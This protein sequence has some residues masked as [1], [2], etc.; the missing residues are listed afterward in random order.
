MKAL[1]ILDRYVTEE[2]WRKCFKEKL[3]YLYNKLEMRFLEIKPDHYTPYKGIK[4][5]VGEPLEIVQEI[6]DVEILVIQFAP[7]SEEM[8]EA[9]KNLKLIA[10]NRSTPVN[11]DLDA[12]TKLRIPVI[13]ATGRTADSAAD[14]TMGL[15]LS[16]VR[17][18]A[19]AF[20]A[21][22]KGT[23]PEV[24]V[25][26]WRESVPELAGKTM[27][28][29][30]VGHIGSKLACRAKSFG[31]RLLGYDPYVS[32][33][34]L[35]NLG[36]E[37]TDLETLLKQSDFISVNVRLT[38]ETTGIIGKKELG[39]MKESAILV[40]TSRGAVIDEDALYEVLKKKRI[41]GA[42]LDVFVKEPIWQ[43][44]ENRF[45]KLENVT[46]TPHMAGPSDEMSYNGVLILAEDIARFLRGE[47]MANVLNPSV[48]QPE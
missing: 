16:E 46:L 2:L 39:M 44:P 22:R 17:H 38:P 11:V 13:K 47:K 30:G 12:A 42:A 9:G 15:L 31:L 23:Y 48:L 41:A 7:V 29:I 43:D 21:V 36:V 5:F 45:L 34:K 6:K 28:I 33:E 19:R 25:K 37:K 10:C 40:N 20:E 3:G 27:G 35:Q 26:K 32:E 4:E 14:F 8:I 1:I 18:I 24:R